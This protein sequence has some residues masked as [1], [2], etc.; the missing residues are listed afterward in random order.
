VGAASCWLSSSVPV[1]GSGEQQALVA[2]PPCF[3]PYYRQG[4]AAR[5]LLGVPSPGDPPRGGGGQL[6][7]PRSRSADIT[8]SDGRVCCAHVASQKHRSPL[9][10]ANFAHPGRLQPAAPLRPS[11]DSRLGTL[12]AGSAT[13]AAVPAR[14]AKHSLNVQTSPASQ[15]APRSPARQPAR[16][17]APRH[18]GLEGGEGAQRWR[19]GGCGVLP[20]QGGHGL[21]LQGAH[22]PPIHRVLPD[23]GPLLL[24]VDGPLVSGIA[25]RRWLSPRP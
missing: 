4:K 3:I 7:A 14:A 19:A 8:P 1:P 25:G 23:V 12:G 15:A 2:F 10:K 5:S 16:A 11:S 22:Q 6:R 21:R 18:R 24:Q 17:P 9:P 13:A 20:G